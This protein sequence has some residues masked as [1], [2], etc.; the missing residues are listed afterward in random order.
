MRIYEHDG[1]KYLSVTSIVDLMFPFDNSGFIKWAISKNLDPKWINEESK[2]L[3]T[4]YHAYFENKFLGISEWADVVESDKDQGYRDSVRDFYD[5]GWEIIDSEQEI[6][7]LGWR[8]AG[9][10]DLIVRNEKL[11]IDRALGDI[12]SWGAWSGKSYKKNKKKLEKV[13][14]QL[15]MYNYA[16][17]NEL[18]KICIIP[19]K[20]GKCVVEDIET[21]YSFI[22]WM[23]ENKKMIDNLIDNSDVGDS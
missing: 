14:V 7:C 2:T 4:R 13:K 1:E 5:Q 17:G 20:T 21:D 19:Q 22:D 12:K 16:L 9:R 8:Y 10:F 23:G 15:N 6:F 11:G 18:P 3:G